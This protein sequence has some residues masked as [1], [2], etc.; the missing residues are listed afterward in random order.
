MFRANKAPA[1]ELERSSIPRYLSQPNVHKFFV[2]NRTWR[3][4]ISSLVN[5]AVEN[6]VKPLQNNN[7]LVQ[8]N[9]VFVDR[10][11]LF[12]VHFLYKLDCLCTKKR[13]LEAGGRF[14]QVFLYYFKPS[15]CQSS[16][17]VRALTVGTSYVIGLASAVSQPPQSAFFFLK[18]I[19][20]GSND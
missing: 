12:A 7:P 5:L 9:V 1:W 3:K 18:S 19:Q 15:S 20:T 14:I 10:W 11:S 8:R 16:I 2:L 6:T 17:Y 4:F 13:S